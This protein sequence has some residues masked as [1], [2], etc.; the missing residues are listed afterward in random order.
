MMKNKSKKVEGV[1]DNLKPWVRFISV[2][3]SDAPNLST[4]RVKGMVPHPPQGMRGRPAG[5]CA[6]SGPEDEND[7]SMNR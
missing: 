1:V 2:R 3:S 5:G 4:T 6:T 7:P